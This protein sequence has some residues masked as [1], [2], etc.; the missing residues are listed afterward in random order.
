MAIGE[1]IGFFR[2]KRG[3][4]QK[5]LGQKI[6][7]P[8][9]SA[10]VRMAQYEVGSRKPKE[11]VT[12]ALAEAL[13]VSP[14]ALN[15]PDIDSLL[16]VAHTLFALEDIYGL[17]IAKEDG[18]YCLEPNIFKSPRASEI[19]TFM[20]AWYEMEAKRKTGEITQEEYDRWRYHYPQYDTSGQWKK[21]APSQKLS[22]WL[23]V[24]LRKNE[25]K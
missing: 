1:R 12:S 13:D 14:R 6:G 3:M 18:S 21:V 9:R 5:Y 10:D 20:K 17:A 23:V 2:K 8:E 4:T 19:Q 25:D 15:V 24:E 11:D 7:F 22:D 16:G